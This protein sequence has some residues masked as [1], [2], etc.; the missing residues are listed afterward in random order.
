MHTPSAMFHGFIYKCATRFLR[1]RAFCA[2]IPTGQN[3]FLGFHF[4][5]VPNSDMI[6][7]SHAS[8]CPTRCNHP[9]TRVAVEERL[10]NFA[11]SAFT[12]HQVGINPTRFF[13]NL[14]EVDVPPQTHAHHPC[15][16]SIKH[17]IHAGQ[18]VSLNMRDKHHG[19]QLCPWP[20]DCTLHTRAEITD[21]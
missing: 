8:S 20:D 2:V 1:P 13:I 6:C 21:Q 17:K 9:Q 15:F 4:Q 11:L 10:H 12:S 16:L 14:S 5:I 3:T 19:T 18:K 7:E